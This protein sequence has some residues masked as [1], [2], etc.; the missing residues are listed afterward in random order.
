MNH[1]QWKRVSQK[2]KLFYLLGLTI[3]F[4]VIILIISIFNEK[5]LT[6]KAIQEPFFESDWTLV[7]YPNKVKEVLVA[8][9]DSLLMSSAFPFV[10]NLLES[11]GINTEKAWTAYFS[12]EE[13]AIYLVLP[14]Q[15]SVLFDQRLSSFTDKKLQIAST[16]WNKLKDSSFNGKRIKEF[17]FIRWCKKKSATPQNIQ[18]KVNTSKSEDDL[19]FRLSAS[20]SYL[21]RNNFSRFECVVTTNLP[22][23]TDLY[24]N[25][26][27]NSLPAIKSTAWKKK[28]EADA[29]FLSVSFDPQVFKE[30]V[31]PHF[32]SE[33]E[34]M[35]PRALSLTTTFLNAWNGDLYVLLGGNKTEN[36]QQV[37]TEMDDN[38]QTV[39]R[40]VTTKTNFLNTVFALSV[41][42]KW[43]S[44]ENTLTSPAPK[45]KEAN[46]EENTTPAISSI[47]P[48]INLQAKKSSTYIDFT[49]MNLSKINGFVALHGSPSAPH[50]LPSTPKKSIEIMSSFMFSIEE[51]SAKSWHIKMKIKE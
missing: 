49:Q 3:V 48:K 12:V 50:F 25:S 33:I 29:N 45:A 37:V 20:A 47:I 46:I 40:I 11:T 23:A 44:F 21:K 43:S 19:A 6:F 5:K 51:A 4:V 22:L 42:D 34:W 38:F 13:Q 27:N 2:N 41:N 15:D 36:K 1:H 8:Q 35:D 26:S 10:F 17:A 31:L 32:S 9:N 18:W 39:E 7:I 30:F 24:V 28:E 16:N 14:I